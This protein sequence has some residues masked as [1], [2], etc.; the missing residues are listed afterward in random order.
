MQQGSIVTRSYKSFLVSG[1]PE[2]LSTARP[3]T[4]GSGC[5]VRSHQP[6]CESSVDEVA[7]DCILRQLMAALLWL[8]P[9]GKHTK[10]MEN[11]NFLMGKLT[12]NG[13]VQ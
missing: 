11:H 2:L 6:F 12:I 13:H 7:L 4:G 10:T 8:L 5:Q 1:Y 3:V 9:S